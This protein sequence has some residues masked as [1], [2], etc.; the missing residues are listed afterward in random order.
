M[1]SRFELT[2][3]QLCMMRFPGRE[4]NMDKDWSLFRRRCRDRRWRKWY[5]AEPVAISMLNKVTCG[6][7]K[8]SWH[9]SGQRHAITS[10]CGASRVSQWKG[11]VSIC[12]AYRPHRYVEQWGGCADECHENVIQ[13]GMPLH[14]Y[15]YW[16]CPDWMQRKWLHPGRQH[17]SLGSQMALRCL[18]EFH[19]MSPWAELT[20]NL[21][22]YPICRCIIIM[23]GLEIQL[24]TKINVYHFGTLFEKMIYLQNKIEWKCL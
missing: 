16:H 10:H 4:V 18:D 1:P 5:A 13:A 7:A 17:S 11:N 6:K 19:E 8:C 3:G 23:L 12:T 24:I 21:Q 20:L 9:S 2:T 22:N 15:L 14:S